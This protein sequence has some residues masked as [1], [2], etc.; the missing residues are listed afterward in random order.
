MASVALALGL[1]LDAPGFFAAGLPQPS[2]ARDIQ[3]NLFQ[4]PEW[5]SLMRTF[6]AAACGILMFI[7]LCATVFARRRGGF[8]YILRGIVGSLGLLLAM[9]PLG[10]MVRTNEM[11]LSAAPLF[12]TGRVS[13]G[14]NEVLTNFR[15]PALYFAG[16]IFIVS[17]IVLSIP[18]PRRKRWPRVTIPSDLQTRT[19]SSPTPQ[20]TSPAAPVNT[21]ADS[22]NT[23][24]SSASSGDSSAEVQHAGGGEKGA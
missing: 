13:A 19:P 11:W 9:L 7:A 1:A 12:Q 15:G 17:L 20:S 4:H 10:S 6:G 3:Q 14:I 24:P 23:E 21:V 5:P 22:S 16:G 18:A 2:V 8:G